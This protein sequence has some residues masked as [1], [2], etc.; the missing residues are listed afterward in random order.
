MARKRNPKIL[1]GKTLKIGAVAVAGALLIKE[2]M[3]AKASTTND[4]RYASGLTDWTNEAQQAGFFNLSNPQGP[5]GSA[6]SGYG[7]AAGGGGKR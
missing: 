2:A 1:S 6:A 7:D 3:K 4:T 5:N